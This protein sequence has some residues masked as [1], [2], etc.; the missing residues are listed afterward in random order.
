MTKL[1][2][3]KLATIMATCAFAFSCVAASDTEVPTAANTTAAPAMVDAV[4]TLSAQETVQQASSGLSAALKADAA[5]L[6]SDPNHIYTLLKQYVLPYFDLQATSRFVLS[7]NWRMA[8]P[9]Q[10]RRFTE[11]FSKSMVKTYIAAM[12]SFSSD[13]VQYISTIQSEPNTATV[14]T[15]VETNKSSPPLS[16]NYDLYLKNGAW[17]VYDISVEGISFGITLRGVYASLIQEEGLDGLIN[18]LTAENAGIPSLVSAITLQ[19][20]PRF[21]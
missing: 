21:G 11:E 3:K 8:T 14:R 19:P 4:Q 20:K 18:K 13:K 1:A 10:K 6:Q 2:R 12:R 7:K 17:K 5:K 9:E 16:I 15:K